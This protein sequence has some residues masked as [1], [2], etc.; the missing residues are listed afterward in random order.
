MGN[1]GQDQA[2]RTVY[3]DAILNASISVCGGQN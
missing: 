3:P 1:A 2:A